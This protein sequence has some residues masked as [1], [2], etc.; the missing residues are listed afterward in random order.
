MYQI[1]VDDDD[2]DNDDELS[3]GSFVLAS[4]PKHAIHHKTMILF[5]EVPT[6]N[7]NLQSQMLCFSFE[8]VGPYVRLFAT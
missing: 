8:S 1:C 6:T 5:Y 7:F 4:L 3:T 2:H